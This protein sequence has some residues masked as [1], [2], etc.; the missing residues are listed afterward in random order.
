[1]DESLSRGLSAAGS[2][3]GM[4]RFYKIVPRKNTRATEK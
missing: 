4:I 2:T 3:N 1:M